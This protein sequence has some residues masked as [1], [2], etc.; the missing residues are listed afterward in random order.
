MHT[1][2]I[3]DRR[4]AFFGATAVQHIDQA[5]IS[6]FPKFFLTAAPN[7]RYT[8]GR[9]V[10]LG[11]RFAIVTDAGWDAMDAKAAK[12]SVAVSVR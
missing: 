1:T 4:K 3:S 6:D 8:V 11:G 5:L 9:P 12:T 7:Q 2:Q 10:P